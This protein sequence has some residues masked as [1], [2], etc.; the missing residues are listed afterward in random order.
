MN[1]F[2]PFTAEQNANAAKKNFTFY[3]GSCSN[4]EQEALQR[5]RMNFLNAVMN[6]P[7][8]KYFLCDVSQGQDCVVENVKVYCGSNSRK[9]TFGNQRIITFDFVMKDKNMSSDAKEEAAKY[10]SIV[11]KIPGIFSYNKY[12]FEKN[13][14]ITREKRNSHKRAEASTNDLYLSILFFQAAILFDFPLV[15]SSQ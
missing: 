5:I 1:P 12:I 14:D 3:T 6:S 4:N 8:A 15:S 7:M 10:V 2:L 9:R 11:T 13:I